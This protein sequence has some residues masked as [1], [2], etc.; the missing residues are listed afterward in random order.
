M[1]LK[2]RLTLLNRKDSNSIISQV[3]CTKRGDVRKAHQPLIREIQV[4][5]VITSIPW[6]LLSSDRVMNGPCACAACS[7]AH[8]WSLLTWLGKGAC[9]ASGGEAYLSLWLRAPT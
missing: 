3:E 5:D 7:H 6:G 2:Q 1:K 9:M 8:P 4:L